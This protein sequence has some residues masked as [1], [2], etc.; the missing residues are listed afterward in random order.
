MQAAAPKSARLVPAGPVPSVPLLPTPALSSSSWSP[1]ER[2]WSSAPSS[3][4]DRIDRLFISKLSP[5]VTKEELWAYFGQFGDITDVYLPMNPGSRAHKGISFVS[6]SST[7]AI[8]KVVD[9]GP[10]ALAGCPV[11]VDVAVPRAP[12]PGTVSEQVAAGTRL[13]LTKV[14]PEISRL[15]LQQ[16]FCQFGELTDCY[17]PPGNKGIA[18]LSYSSAACAQIVLQ[19]ATHEV[20]TGC[21]VLVSQAFDRQCKGGGK[22]V[23]PVPA[24]AGCFPGLTG[25]GAAASPLAS[26]LDPNTAQALV[27]SFAL[28]SG[29]MGSS[30]ANG[31]GLLGQAGS[32]G[33]SNGLAQQLLAQQL[34]ASTAGAQQPQGGAHLFGA[35]PAV[36]QQQTM[37]YLQQAALQQQLLQ[38]HQQAMLGHTQP[39][40]PALGGDLT[41]ALTAALDGQASDDPYAALR[42]QAAQSLSRAA[43]Y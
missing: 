19:N 24:A 39:A 27:N 42:F 18:F 7:E 41:A 37:Q 2:S 43:P 3:G 1:P 16:Y 8:R 40:A 10:H 33:Q 6:F 17:I 5:D 38:L 32:C 20:R 36:G 31:L 23:L 4:G 25:F 13:F 14:T 26:G 15:D 34:L 12:A 9:A 30:L 22:G 29:G 21:H 35:L 11:H 28:S